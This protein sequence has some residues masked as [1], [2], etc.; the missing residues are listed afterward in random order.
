MDKTHL[1][2]DRGAVGGV[3]LVIGG[4]YEARTDP[5]VPVDEIRVFG[6]VV[7]NLFSGGHAV[8][9]LARVAVQG[10]LVAA[11][12]DQFYG[13]FAAL[14]DLLTPRDEVPGR[15]KKKKKMKRKSQIPIMDASTKEKK[16]I[17]V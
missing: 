8:E 2:D 1:P 13:I 6:E 5:T 9:V 11:V 7:T 17:S 4:A 15:K 10:H 12:H 3:T 16:E 14:G